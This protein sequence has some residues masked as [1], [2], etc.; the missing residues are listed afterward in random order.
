M[1]L[2]LSSR[3]KA[4]FEL[5]QK[6][7]DYHHISTMGTEFL[8][9]AM[10]ETED[11]LCHFLLNEYDITKE[12]IEAK[13]T[14]IFI[15][16]E[17]GEEYN[18]NLKTILNQAKVLAGEGKIKDEHLFMAILM[19][20]NT[21]ACSILRSLDLEIDELIKD[22]KEIYDF[23]NNKED[24]L[25]V[26]NVTKNIKENGLTF[27]GRK[28]Y[29]EHM[30]V[31]INRKYKNNPL[32]VGNAGVGKSALVEG[33][34]KRL[35]EEKSEITILSLNLTS[36]L[37][38]TRYRG[39]F[40]ERFDKFIKEIA[41]KKNVIIFIDEIHVIM[42]AAT[43]EGNLDVANM[44]K[45]FLA[46]NDIKV[47]GATTL[48]EYHKT[49]AKDKALSR[50]FQA[51]FVSEPSLEE[52]KEIIF[53]LKKDYEEF[54]NVKIKDNDLEYLIEESNRRIKS[55]F[56]PDKCLDVLDDCM[57]YNQIHK[58]SVVKIIDIDKA[59][60]G[61]SIETKPYNA[62][63]YPKLNEYRWLYDVGLLEQKPLI[64][65][66]YNG[67]NEGLETLS[68]ELSLTFN[69]GFEQ[70]L[71]ID[72]ASF[73]E[74][75]MLSSLIGSPPGYIGYEDEGILVKHILEYPMSIVI[76]K[77]YNLAHSSIKAFIHSLLSKGS[78][79]DQRG[80]LTDLSQTIIVVD[81][82][83]S[84][85]NIGF[86]KIDDEGDKLFDEVFTSEQKVNMTL[87]NKYMKALQKLDYEISFDFDINDT[88]K[89]LVNNYLYELVNNNESG[90]YKVSIDSLNK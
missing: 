16:R 74:G 7:A 9:L 88:N 17:K 10:F 30:N 44:L 25:F 34:A 2:N 26:T 33:Y 37:A 78:F 71:D 13:T 53:G 82:I 65:I 77:N 79:V 84:K 56:R 1:Q 85:N 59:I 70:T 11:T 22:V 48:D 55:K 90:S 42:G 68:N 76:F 83:E 46:R 62:I 28:N 63:S 57:S 86:S 64:K 80:R 69:I 15:L 18:K 20:P 6:Y 5:A 32:L 4:I 21:I 72:L 8:I 50:R 81:G 75:F 66:K 14:D 87:N 27:I 45:P 58:N 35:I 52:T 29:L 40:E 3:C 47:I 38:G 51:I 39:D 41:T 89:T 24:L 31:I 73:K 60:Q 49:I 54:H 12:E 67:S 43:T 61:Y 23:D 36:M 19:N